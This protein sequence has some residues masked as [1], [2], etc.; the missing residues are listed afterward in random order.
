VALRAL[1]AGYGMQEAA[2]PASGARAAAKP[3]GTAKTQGAAPVHAQVA[4]GQTNRPTTAIVW[5]L[6]RNG[7]LAP[8]KVRT[9]ITDFTNTAITQVLQG[10]LAAGDKVVTGELAQTTAG[11]PG[12]T[13]RPGR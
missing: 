13:G 4:G 2:A 6:D 3:A 7:K 1:L 8:V 12:A 5:T 9:G 10:H 11:L